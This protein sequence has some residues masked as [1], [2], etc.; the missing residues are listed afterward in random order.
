[1]MSDHR[2]YQKYGALVEGVI[3]IDEPISA[4]RTL[5]ANLNSTVRPASDLERRRISVG[6]PMSDNK[7]WF[8][9]A[10]LNIILPQ[11]ESAAAVS[12]IE[13]KM[14]EGFGPPLHVHTDED[15]TFYALEGRFRF[16]VAGETLE[17]ATGQ[18][19]HVPGGTVHTFRVL[20]DVGRLLTV[21]NGA[22]EGMVRAA[23]VPARFEDLPPPVP[24]TPEDQNRLAILC[25]QNGIQFLGPPIE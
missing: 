18:S 5:L 21:T 6:F 17:L 14:A 1:M 13:H 16:R 20:S 4:E 10:Y 19:L 22:F 15:E 9:N 8:M 11:A 23:S 7:V 3:P 25:N 2:S 24:F 12:I